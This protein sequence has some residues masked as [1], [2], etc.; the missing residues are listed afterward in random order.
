VEADLEELRQGGYPFAVIHN[1]DADATKGRTGIPTPG[2]YPSFCWTKR[3]QE[4]LSAHKPILLRQPVMP[5]IVP[6]VSGTGNTRVGTFGHIEPKK[7]TFEMNRWARRVGVPF[8]AVGPD[9]LEATYDVYYADLR[10]YGCP[11]RLHGW[12]DQ[13]EELAPLVADCTHFL[14]VLTDSKKGTGGSPTSPRLAG[15]FNRPV[16][17]V[18]DEYTFAED[19]YYVYRDLGEIKR[20]HLADMKLPKYDWSPDA[21]L[22]ALTNRTL[23]FWRRT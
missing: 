6:S 18:D 11:M 17:V 15:L 5:P 13:I 8:V 12:R 14:F 4:R 20:E 22:D 2:D 9:V 16:I 3:G 23:E 10:S 21:Y 7:Q 19:G 1:N